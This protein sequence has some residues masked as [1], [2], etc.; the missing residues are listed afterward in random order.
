MDERALVPLLTPELRELWEQGEVVVSEGRDPEKP[1]VRWASG[2]KRG[3]YAPGSGVTPFHVDGDNSRKSAVKRTHAY[4]EL[5]QSVV[6]EERFAWL[7]D[8]I[9]ETV[10]GFSETKECPECGTPVTFEKRPQA[11]PALKLI[12]QLAGK[13]T[14]R[15]EVDVEMRSIHAELEARVD[16]KELIVHRLDPQERARRAEAV[17]A[18]A[19]VVD[20]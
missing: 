14:E 20:E 16:P 12:E 4:R 10:E 7:L 8:K 1:V 19:E 13:A 11:G 17:E 5:L 15:K 9:F 18:Q 3:Q 6:D 2:S